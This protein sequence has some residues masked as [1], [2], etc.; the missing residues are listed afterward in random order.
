MNNIIKHF[1]FQEIH[2]FKSFL[3]NI[4]VINLHR[5]I[6]IVVVGRKPVINA[7]WSNPKERIYFLKSQQV[8]YHR[9]FLEKI[10]A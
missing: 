10:S 4:V 1:I 9:M 5:Q 3:K 7:D 6:Q 8:F 2:N